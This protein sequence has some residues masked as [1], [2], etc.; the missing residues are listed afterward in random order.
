M[1]WVTNL[2]KVF[3]LNVNGFIYNAQGLFPVMLL[4]R[5]HNAAGDDGAK[6]LG[7][8]IWKT[9]AAWKTLGGENKWK[10]IAHVDNIRKVSGC[11]YL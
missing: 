11:I 5:V 3:G 1:Y 4:T 10:N 2:D 9:F 7:K 8:R 6:V